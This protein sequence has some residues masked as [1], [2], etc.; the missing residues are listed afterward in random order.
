MATNPT[1]PNQPPDTLQGVTAGCR[2]DLHVI[3]KAGGGRTLQELNPYIAGTRVELVGSGAKAANTVETR[4][5]HNAD[6]V[7]FHSLPAGRYEVRFVTPTGVQVDQGSFNGGGP[8][9]KEQAV[10]VTKGV[11]DVTLVAPYMATLDAEISLEPAVLDCFA[12]VDLDCAC[13]RPSDCKC[14]KPYSCGC[15]EPTDR[16]QPINGVTFTL[17]RQGKNEWCKT[18]GTDGNDD[19]HYK[20][21]DLTPDLYEV[22]PSSTVEGKGSGC[23]YHLAYNVPTYVQLA[24]G[25]SCC[26]L[27]IRYCRDES[28]IFVS[29]CI[30]GRSEC[31]EP[32]I[33]CEG[34]FLLFCDGDTNFCRY[35]SCHHHESAVFSGL[36]AGTYTLVLQSPFVNVKGE[37]YELRTPRHGAI[38]VAL[39]AGQNI[40]LRHHFRFVRAPESQRAM[41]ISGRVTDS[42]GQGAT[43]QLVDLLQAKTERVLWTAATDTDGLYRILWHHWRHQGEVELRIGK[44][45]VRVPKETATVDAATVDAAAYPTQLLQS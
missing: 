33:A 16:Q 3:F 44:T 27:P 20:F 5:A 9:A 43:H 34:E 13:D 36:P 12:Y 17:R 41:E 22:F 10:K 26:T 24:P 29:A 18:T 30:D 45:R 14:E 8:S 37:D 2:C 19:G 42:G 4:I 31:C 39:C 35:A 6:D 21:K 7:F 15:E 32:E 40:D 38:R 28:S 1:P 25:R 23:T 11:A